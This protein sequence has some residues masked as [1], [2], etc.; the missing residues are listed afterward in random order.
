MFVQ[1]YNHILVRDFA[2]APLAGAVVFVTFAFFRKLDVDA[3]V[4]T[5]FFVLRPPESFSGS[6]DASS[7]ASIVASSSA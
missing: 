1:C 3:F 4:A 5:R 7:T 2:S 6:A